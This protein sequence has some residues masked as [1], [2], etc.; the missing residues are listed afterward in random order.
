MCHLYNSV[1]Q[2]VGACSWH[3]HRHHN[4]QA[5][6]FTSHTTTSTAGW[7]PLLPL[8]AKQFPASG[9]YSLDGGKFLNLKIFCISP[10][11]GPTRDQ[12]CNLIKMQN[13]LKTQNLLRTQENKKG[14]SIFYKYYSHF[15]DV[16]RTQGIYSN[17]LDQIFTQDRMRINV[18]IKMFG[19][20]FS[21]RKYFLHKIISYRIFSV[22]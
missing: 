13:Q 22:D 18:C 20:Y 8:A 7:H 9:N 2:S 15:L 4:Y 17:H 14:I 10:R 11:I 12:H 1:W 19:F 6:G 5:E 16:Y 21:K 3:S